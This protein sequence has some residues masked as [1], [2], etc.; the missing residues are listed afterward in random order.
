MSKLG[1]QARRTPAQ[2]LFW[3]VFLI[4]GSIF[5]IATLLLA[6]SPATVST[7]VHKPEVLV[8]VGGLVVLLGANA[9]LVRASISP[10]TALTVV[11][12][13]VDLMRPGDRLTRGRNRPLA[14]LVDTFNAMLDRL[15]ADRSASSAHALAAQEGERKRVAQELHDE[16]GQSLTVVLLALKGAVDRA[17]ADLKNEL[18]GVQENVRSS[19]EEV[20]RVAQRL[21]PSMLEDLGLLSA[22]DALAEEFTQANG[23]PVAGTPLASVDAVPPGL[24]AEIELVVYRIAQESLTNV[25]RH[26]DATRVDLSL[27]STDD[28]VTLCI[29][30]DGN[31]GVLEEGPGIRGM[32]ERALLIGAQLTFIAPPGGGTR[33]RLVVPTAGE[34]RAPQ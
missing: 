33:V 9:L 26:A 16:I 5:S 11:M 19:L 20:G 2:V 31:G 32:R 12:R 13:R 23:V 17:P 1:S 15:E 29:T 34:S 3:R 22:L 14:D 8:L 24:G 30:D 21:R 27:T 28:A 7:P 6:V 25:A 4:N 18:D 10:L